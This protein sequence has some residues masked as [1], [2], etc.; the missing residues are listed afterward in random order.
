MLNGVLDDFHVVIIN[1]DFMKPLWLALE[2]GGAGG[3]GLGYQSFPCSI[4]TFRGNLRAMKMTTQDEI[5]L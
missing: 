2:A 1:Q 3:G 4:Q 5:D